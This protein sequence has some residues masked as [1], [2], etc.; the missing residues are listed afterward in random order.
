[1][2]QQEN[3]ANEEF[4]GPNQCAITHSSEGGPRPRVCCGQKLIGGMMGRLGIIPSMVRLGGMGY[5]GGQ[6]AN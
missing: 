1:M 4:F 5:L 3:D 2:V 6:R